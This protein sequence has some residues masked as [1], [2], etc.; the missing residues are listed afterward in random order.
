MPFLLEKAVF[1]ID[2]VHVGGEVHRW[3]PAYIVMAYIVMARFTGGS[4][5]I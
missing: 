2:L 1:L 5:P 4:R 3:K